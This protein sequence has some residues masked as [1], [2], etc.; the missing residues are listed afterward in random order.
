MLKTA[1]VLVLVLACSGA[2][3]ADE[4]LQAYK[5]RV[6]SMSFS[7][8]SLE[9]SDQFIY[10]ALACG[11]TE[12]ATLITAIAS[13][14]VF[15]LIGVPGLAANALGSAF[16]QKKNPDGSIGN[17]ENSKDYYQ[18]ILKMN[19]RLEKA[20]FNNN[21]CLPVAKKYSVALQEYLVRIEANPPK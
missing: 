5:L 6:A 9:T 17:L 12:A 8:L 18:L 3:A 7:D 10:T 20:G 15:G 16:G 11:G 4:N 13:D 2:K 19:E 14:V 21:I 1:I